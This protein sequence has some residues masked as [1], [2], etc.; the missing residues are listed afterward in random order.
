MSCSG[1]H[2]EMLIEREGKLSGDHAFYM[3]VGAWLQSCA[4]LFNEYT[5]C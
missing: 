5:L 3:N 2:L 4:R 1:Q